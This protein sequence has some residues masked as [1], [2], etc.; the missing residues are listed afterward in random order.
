MSGRVRSF[1]PFPFPFPFHNAN[2]KLNNKKIVQYREKK[3]TENDK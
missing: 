1:F 2:N 3:T